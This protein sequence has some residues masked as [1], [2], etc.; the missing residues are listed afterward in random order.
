[1]C[2]MPACVYTHGGDSTKSPL[3]QH[4]TDMNTIPGSLQDL[5]ELMTSM[6]VGP[7]GVWGFIVLRNRHCPFKV[8]VI[9]SS[10]SRL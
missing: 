7:S 6:L 3:A 8:M 9:D 2:E 1:M 10:G 4:T 5:K